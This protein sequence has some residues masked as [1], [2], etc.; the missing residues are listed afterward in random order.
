MPHRTSGV[1]FSLVVSHFLG[2]SIFKRGIHCGS[3]KSNNSNVNKLDIHSKISRTWNLTRSHRF[4]AHG[5]YLWETCVGFSS[6]G[7]ER[8]GRIYESAIRLYSQQVGVNTWSLRMCRLIWRIFGSNFD[9]Q[10]YKYVKDW[11]IPKALLHTQSESHTHTPHLPHTKS[12]I[13]TYK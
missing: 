10:A 7:T 2:R 6:E 1:R 4:V 9:K 12:H 11:K 5:T 13:C 8:R 3:R